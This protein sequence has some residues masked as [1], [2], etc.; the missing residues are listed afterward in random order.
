MTNPVHLLS[1]AALLLVAFLVGAVVGTLLRLI[2]L[3]VTRKPAAVAAVAVETSMAAPPLVTTPVIAPLPI[4]PTPIAPS[5]AD[6][7]VPDFAATL[8]AL[9]G[10]A[11]PADILDA[12]PARPEPAGRPVPEPVVAAAAPAMQP[13]R[14]AG[15]TTSGLQVPA[16]PHD[17]P[18]VPVEAPTERT[19]PRTADV[20]PFP[21]TTPEAPP[22][23][24]SDIVVGGEA[25]AVVDAFDL[26]AAAAEEPLPVVEPV[27]VAEAA[28]LAAPASPVAE[29]DFLV[30][31]EEAFALPQGEEPPPIVL[32]ATSDTVPV[33]LIPANAA[34]AAVISAELPVPQVLTIGSPPLE[35]SRE[36]PESAAAMAEPLL[37]PA[38]PMAAPVPEVAPQPQAEALELGAP[39][40]V[41]RRPPDAAEPKSEGLPPAA[42]PDEPVDEDAA[43]RAIEGNWTPRR[44]PARQ[45]RP[46]SPPEGVNHAV[47]AS[48]RAV[49]AARRTAEA[50]VAE[51]AEAK[52]EVKAEAGRPVGL[53]GPRDGRKDD[54]THIIG[55]LPVIETALNKLGVY[56]FDQ[57]GALTDENIG[58]IEGHLG[59][60]G[61]ISRELWREQAR[62][63]SAVLK[64]KRTAEKK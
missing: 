63:L 49:T 54:L 18:V 5:P 24:I 23:P 51:V 34:V 14:V 50:V 6:V 48:A 60:P 25:I 27:A 29:D 19:E 41:V 7:P 42:P 26:V 1:V 21:T 32:D 52:A 39:V 56:H 44:P 36:T 43:M 10:E 33:P 46:V 47:A 4:A 17:D 64:P 35:T 55:V 62:E 30:V 11:P 59:V 61:R 22:K 9:A 37:P 57:V 38:L 45:P 15:E 53:D 58:W 12:A 16:P 40:E 8:I 3:R 28:V 20:I 31:G 13:A 2:V